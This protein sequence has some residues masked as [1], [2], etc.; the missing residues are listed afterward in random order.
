MPNLK[1]IIQPILNRKFFFSYLLTM[2]FLATLNLIHIHGNI[3]FIILILLLC[4]SLYLIRNRKSEQIVLGMLAGVASIVI[5]YYF[6]KSW[7]TFFDIV[8]WDFLVF[9]I[10]GKAT[11]DGLALYDP[12]SFSNILSSIH[13][14]FTVSDSFTTAAIQTGVIYPPT[15]MLMLAPIGYLDVT[16]ANIVWRIFV[17]S[18]LVIDMILIYRIFKINESKW[19]QILI[20]VALTLILPGSISTLGYSQTNFFLLFFILLIYKDPDNW[21]AG[22]FL[23]LAVII[24]PIPVVWGLYF[25]INR[26]W[27]PIFSF[28]ITGIVVIFLTIMLVGINNFMTFF[29]SPPTSRIP[30][31]SFIESINQSMNAVFSR[32]SLQLGMDSLSGYMNWI[33]LFVSLILVILTCIAS[34]KLA[35]TNL[36]AS[37]LIFLPLSLLIFPGSLTHYVVQLLPLFFA[38]LMIKDKTSLLLFT[39]F[40]LVLSV[41]TFTASFI[42]LAVFIL[43]A[44]LDIPV[45]TKLAIKRELT[46]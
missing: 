31:G 16:T 4:S 20:I 22:M 1:T 8:E 29:T 39:A 34:Y 15:T 40:L 3:L 7:S 45:F 23:A 32:I 27:K 9:Y 25:L 42:I 14:P 37:F 41:S 17:L 30:R 5:A 12:A 19:F 43:Y 18:F 2:A 26:K 10:D 21:K 44:F 13:L 33:V 46:N 24:K 11:V 28:A 36:K 6:Y 38:M 35:K